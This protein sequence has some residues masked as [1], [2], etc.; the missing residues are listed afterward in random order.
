MEKV[1]AEVFELVPSCAYRT[2]AKTDTK[3]VFTC[4]ERE[5]ADVACH[6]VCYSGRRG[7]GSGA[8]GRGDGAQLILRTASNEH[9]E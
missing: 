1:T 4:G 6:K 2:D 7:A 8:A 3:V 5:D 9:H